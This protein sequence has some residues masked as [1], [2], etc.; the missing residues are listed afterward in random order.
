MGLLDETVSVPRRTMTLFFLIDTSGSMEGNKIGAVNDAIPNVL[1]LLK[2]IQENNPDAEIK[3]AALEFSSGVNW[4]YDEPKLAED[5]IWQDVAAGGLTSLGQACKELDSKLSMSHG[6][7]TKSE[8]G[9]GYY[10]PAIILLSDGGPTD[11]FQSGLKAL[12]E[13]NWFKK[14]I[15]IAI[16][17]GDDADKDV[18]KDFTGSPE[19]VITVHNIEALKMIIRIVSVTS[20]QVGSKSSSA[21]DTSK[22]D[23]VIKDV[24]QAASQVD[25]AESASGVDSS[26]YIDDWG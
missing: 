5:F 25:G 14:A 18:L 4:L 26:K 3:V 10:A 9:S 1:P 12:K 19:A 23:Q 21:G 13:N 22:Q 7:M 17:I 2:E 15:R 16:A 8:T 20:S 24:Q 11:D 6:Y